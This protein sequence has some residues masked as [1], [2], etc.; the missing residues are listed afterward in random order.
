MAERSTPLEFEDE[1]KPL[2]DADIDAFEKRVGVRF[3]SEYRA[4]LLAHNGGRVKPAVLGGFPRG[5]I[6]NFLSLG[7]PED[8]AMTWSYFKI[9]TEPRMPPEHIPIADCRGGDLLTMVIDGP[10]RGQIFYWDH[11]EEGNETYTYDNLYFVAASLDELFA[12]LYDDRD[13]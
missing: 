10:K 9:P 2:Q 13:D 7:P 5:E 3:P 12:G 11:E 6:Q 1:G 4:F 8:A